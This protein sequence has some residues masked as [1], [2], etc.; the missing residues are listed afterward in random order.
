MTNER[1]YPDGI[2][3]DEAWRQRQRA[4]ELERG[5]TEAAR[6]IIAA[7]DSV[8]RDGYVAWECLAEAWLA[9]YGE[10]EK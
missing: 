6:L 2:A 7:F 10:G 5:I 3:W 9:K 8:G 1:P 4:D